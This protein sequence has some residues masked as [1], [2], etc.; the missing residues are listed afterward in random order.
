[1]RRILDAVLWVFIA[2]GEWLSDRLGV[3]RAQNRDLARML[4]NSLFWIIVAVI[5][6]AIWTS[7]LPIYQ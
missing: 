6:L 4:I 3:T 5:G 2:P 7:R 1:M